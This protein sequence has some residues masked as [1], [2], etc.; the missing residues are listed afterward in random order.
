MP[1]YEVRC[2]ICE[3]HKEVRCSYVTVKEMTCDEC[4]VIFEIVP[5]KT[6]FKIEGFS[7]ENG[8]SVVPDD[9]YDPRVGQNT[10]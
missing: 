6:Q 9:H 4:G 10:W 1:I 3:D 5:S 7:M 8:Y 2:P